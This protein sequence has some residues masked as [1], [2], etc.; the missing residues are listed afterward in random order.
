MTEQRLEAPPGITRIGGLLKYDVSEIPW[1]ELKDHT[2]RVKVFGS[3]RYRQNGSVAL[4]QVKGCEKE[5]KWSVGWKNKQ[6]IL[7][8]DHGED[9]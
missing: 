8:F 7:C 4:C 5:A 9:A 1:E 6:V 3:W 2:N